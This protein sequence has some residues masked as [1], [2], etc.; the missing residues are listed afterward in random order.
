[1]PNKS[2]TSRKKS[3]SIRK[4]RSSK[5]TKRKS[6]KSKSINLQLIDRVKISESNFNGSD[7]TDGKPYLI[8]GLAG[9]HQKFKDHTISEAL[10][11]A[12]NAG[13]QPIVGSSYGP[14]EVR[15]W[16]YANV[17]GNNGGYDWTT[18]SGPVADFILEQT[19]KT[20]DDNIT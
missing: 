3:I 1:M 5:K 16:S 15:Y 17:F 12:W 9:Y 14:K 11:E 18:K 8:M 19:S 7:P 13:I 6:S 10:V 20:S 4:S 2:K